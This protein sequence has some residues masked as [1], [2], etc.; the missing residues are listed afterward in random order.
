MHEYYRGLLCTFITAHFIDLGHC[1]H[2]PSSYLGQCSVSAKTQLWPVDA[3]DAVVRGAVLQPMSPVLGAV[4]P[5]PGAVLSSLACT[6]ARSTARSAR[7]ADRRFTDARIF[8]IPHPNTSFLAFTR[9]MKLN[10]RFCWKCA[11]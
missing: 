9:I 11:P 6:T 3:V 5:V 7:L 10:L 8:T 1:E 2:W 4:D